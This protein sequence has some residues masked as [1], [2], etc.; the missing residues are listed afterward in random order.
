MN[1]KTK[2]GRDGELNMTSLNVS[3]MNSQFT[4]I[5]NVASQPHSSINETGLLL[6]TSNTH[7]QQQQRHHGS[8]FPAQSPNPKESLGNHYTQ[9]GSS[10][11]SQ[12]NQ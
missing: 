9:F 1:Y 4:N 10:N 5:G 12:E 6:N 8:G 7:Y 3:G 11:N 2:Y